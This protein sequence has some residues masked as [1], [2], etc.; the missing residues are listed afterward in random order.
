MSWLLIVN[1]FY[2]GSG[3]IVTERFESQNMCVKAAH[4]IVKSLPS[5]NAQIHA[6]WSCTNLR[7]IDE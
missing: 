3:S 5:N 1:L 2:M 4:I 6:K 7:A